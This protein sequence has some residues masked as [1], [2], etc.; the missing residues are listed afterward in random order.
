MT[1]IA[2]LR[3]INIGGRHKMKMADLRQFLTENGF[4]NVKTYIQSGNVILDSSINNSTEVA[5]KIHQIITDKYGFDIKVVVK[6]PEEIIKITNESPTEMIEN[7]PHN[8]VFAMMLDTI[9]LEENVD[10]F[11]ERDFTPDLLS[12]END[13]VYFACLNGVSK[14]KLSNNLIEK[15]LKVNGTT[16]NYKTMVKLL[17]MV[18]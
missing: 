15:K 14:S 8:R 12:I 7:I 9:P 17:S 1:Y 11:L 5:E 18:E 10:I 16:R 4:E 3:G 6:S 2:L 13:V